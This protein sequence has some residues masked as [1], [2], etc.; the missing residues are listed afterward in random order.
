MLIKRIATGFTLAAAS[1]A[2]ICWGLL[3]MTLE[4]LLL[5]LIGLLEFDAM[6]RIK[7]ISP[8]KPTALICGF[9]IVASALPGTRLFLP[10]LFLCTLII[11]IVF[12]FRKD[13]HV[14]SYL[15]VGAT[16][17]GIIYIPWFFSHLVLLRGYT[18][19]LTISG[20]TLDTGALYVLLVLFGTSFSDIFAYFVGRFFGRVKLCP[21]ISPGKTV[22]GSLGGLLASMAVTA[23]FG[24]FLGWSVHLSIL[25]GLL[26]G[27]TAQLGDLWESV[28]KRDVGIK[29]SGNILPGHG[30]ILDRFDSFFFTAPTVY[31]FLILFVLPQR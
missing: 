3:P 22:E 14:S 20:I 6:A 29:D 13:F 19:K 27:L 21:G 16:L 8:S 10:V 7:G 9:L 31:Y 11:F 24:R 25:L 12:I 26:L 15:D 23:A 5:S 1:I 17:M 4:V 2:L 30:G 28:L 18:E